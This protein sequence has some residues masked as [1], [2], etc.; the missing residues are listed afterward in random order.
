MKQ[1]VVSWI[2]LNEHCSRVLLTCYSCPGKFDLG[3]ASLGQA[4]RSNLA[5]SISGQWCVH[6]FI[7]KRDIVDTLIHASR[8][9]RHNM[10]KQTHFPHTWKSAN[11]EKTERCA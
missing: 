6:H 9:D 4:L 1:A 7:G 10:Y 3:W 8:A 5:E 11:R 2:T